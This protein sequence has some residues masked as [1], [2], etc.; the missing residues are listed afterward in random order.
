VKL[1]ILC[2]LLINVVY[3]KKHNSYSVSIACVFNSVQNLPCNIMLY[4]NLTKM[5]IEH[6]VDQFIYYEGYIH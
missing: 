5:T 3:T 4:R 6:F 1:N 2:E